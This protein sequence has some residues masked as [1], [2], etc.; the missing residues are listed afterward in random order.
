MTQECDH[1]KTKPLGQTNQ[2]I[3]K[4]IKRANDEIKGLMQSARRL[5]HLYID[6]RKSNEILQENHKKVKKHHELLIEQHTKVRKSN[7]LLQEDHRKVTK[8]M[9][10]KMISEQ[11]TVPWNIRA[12]NKEMF[13]TWKDND[14]KM[15]I[16]TRAAEHVLKCIKENSCVTI[17]ASSGV[18][19]TATLRH[20]ALQMVKEGYDVLVVTEPCDIVK[21][22]NPNK[23]TLFVFDDLCGNFSVDL[24]DIKRWDPVMKNIKMILEKKK[25][26]MLAACRLQVYQDEKF[27][28]LSVFKSCV[29]NLLSEN[30]CLTKTEKQSL[31]ELYLKSKAL[32]ITGYYN[33]YDCF[34]LLCKLYHDH[35][36]LNITDFFQNPFT[37][38]EAEVHKFFEKGHHA[39]YCALALCVI[40]NNK[41][42]EE[43]L[44]DEVN[45]ETRTIIENTCEACRLDRGTSRLVLQDELDSLTHTF[46]KKE[47]NM[48]K[49][50]H[51]K[52]F[53]FLAKIYGTKIIDCLIQNADSGLI[54]ERFLLERKDDM[55]QFITIIP[56]K[57]HHLYIQR[58]VDDWSKG[59]LQDVFSNINMKIPH[60]RQKYLFY[61]NT[62]DMSYQRQL[63]NICD[64]NDDNNNLY[65]V[66]YDTAILH[67]CDIGDISLVQWCCNQGVNVNRCS[68]YGGSSVIIACKYGHKEIVKMLLDRGADYNKCD[69]HDE[70]PVMKACEHGHTEIVKMLLDI[71]ADY[72]KCDDD[73]QSPVMKACKHG[74]TEIVKMLLDIG[75]DYNEC[76][77]DGQSPVMKACEHGHTEIVKM[78]LDRGADYNKCDYGVSHL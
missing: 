40:F 47:Q 17:T 35:P 57:Y 49:I 45:E 37:V 44:T 27:K 25:K 50:L 61:L 12:R 52:I 13:K 15:F 11:D 64:D 60:F 16:K 26:K 46:I 62:L 20:V 30:I 34:P 41:L 69:Y 10:I 4:D 67:C 63:A 77:D 53:D 29:S 42:K 2:E 74:H 8:E 24:S 31:A 51:D 38:Y 54:K 43:I 39:K 66:H 70:S 72:N 59:K 6:L 32:E 56:Q 5:E 68:Y 33:L 28:S 65:Y 14:D 48:Y 71:G 23:K 55:D 9:E 58:M 73:G 22:N 75:A 76:D 19:K 1:L 21:Y 7:E 78:L 18:G 36:K 3:M